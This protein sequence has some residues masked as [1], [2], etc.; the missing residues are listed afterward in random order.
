MTTNAVSGCAGTDEEAKAVI[1]NCHVKVF[2]QAERQP[3]DAAAAE[4][5]PVSRADALLAL[6]MEQDP[7]PAMPTPERLTAMV[8]LDARLLALWGTG[9]DGEQVAMLCDTDL[10]AIE[11]ALDDWEAR[12]GIQVDDIAPVFGA[13]AGRV[14]GP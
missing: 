14:S 6:A 2:F 12:L 9:L 13:R 4:A 10:E 1:A 8:T 5:V 11:A 3:P 7:A